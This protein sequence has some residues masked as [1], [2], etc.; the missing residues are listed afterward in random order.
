MAIVGSGPGSLD[1]GPGFI[2]GHEVVVRINNYKLVPAATGSRTDVFF[3]FFGKSVRKTAAE[4]SG[5][6]VTLCM[7]KCPCALAIDSDWHRERNK[8]EGVDFRWIYDD[9]ADWWFCD[10]YV[11]TLA[12]FLKVFET[13]GRHIPTTGFAAIHEILLAEPVSLYL[14][15]F[16]FFRSGIH[17]LNEP[18]RAKNSD[19]PIGHMPERELAWLAENWSRHPLAGDPALM[20]ALKTAMVPA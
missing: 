7:A 12:D 8:M 6:G 17:N 18:W 4:L 3:S 11:P 14:T 19:D 9:R 5:D 1:N 10:T 20:R 2:D 16:D 15:G 13:L